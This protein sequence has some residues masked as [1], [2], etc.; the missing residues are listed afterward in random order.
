MR[1]T[2]LFITLLVFVSCNIEKLDSLVE[3]ESN[4]EFIQLTNS[5]ITK[6]FLS[7]IS[8][9]MRE[10]T[11]QSGGFEK[12]NALVNELINN[13]RKQLQEIRRINQRVSGQCLISNSK[14]VN[15]SRSFANLLRYFKSRG[16]LALS[17][18][19]EAQNMLN[20]RKQQASDYSVA[21][22]RIQLEEKQNVDSSNKRILAL[23]NAVTQVNA[24]LKAIA[25][26][27]PSTKTS[28]IEE[29]VKTSVEAYKKSMKFPI[30]YDS[31]MIQLAANDKKV[32]TRLFQWL[33]I[34]K[35]TIVN[36]LSHAQSSKLTLVS[37]HKLLNEDLLNIIRLEKADAKRLGG[38]IVNFTVL[39][40]NYNDNEKI[41]T[42]LSTQTALVLRNNKKWCRV[43][44]NSYGQN[45]QMMEVQLKTFVALKEW[46]R[47][48]YARVREWIKKK[49]SNAK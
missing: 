28:F 2:I 36:A 25:D 48:N 6:V 8:L 27:T 43:E 38:A 9:R 32:K 44:A 1:S 17:E 20:N 21:Q 46:L 12:V 3:L 31:D 33:N 15:R 35:A 16:S 47:K 14:L 45:K 34:L 39:I 26:W 13:N 4:P 42:A 7:A 37:H 29:K 19:S 10:N 40:K 49:Y 18:K 41:Y 23:Q 24:A 5:P 22:K 11:E 30:S